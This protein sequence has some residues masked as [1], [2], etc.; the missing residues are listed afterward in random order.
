MV[1]GNA[2]QVCGGEV[3]PYRHDWVFRCSRCGVLS[4]SLEVA[5]PSEATQA[6][7]DEAAREA[8]LA[9]LRRRN[10][11]RLLGTLAGLTPL[12]RRLLDVGSGPG[13]LL[14]QAQA[15]GFS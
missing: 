5:I 14:D 2:C 8:G 3:R 11:A 4:S 6:V 1:N 9:T 12:P 13:F 15:A 10:N 7:I